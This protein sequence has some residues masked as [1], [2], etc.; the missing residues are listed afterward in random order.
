[1]SYHVYSLYLSQ[2]GFKTGI[3]EYLGSISRLWRSSFI[4]YA[5]SHLSNKEDIFCSSS[6]SICLGISVL[7][8]LWKQIMRL[9][10]LHGCFLITAMMWGRSKGLPRL[11]EAVNGF[12]SRAPLDTFESQIDPI[13]S[14]WFYVFV[15]RDNN[16]YQYSQ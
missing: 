11:I 5:Q 6:E 7:K 13:V 15:Y 8:L 4:L 3:I 9:Q 2:L 14:N 12:H 16:L 1:M 10:S